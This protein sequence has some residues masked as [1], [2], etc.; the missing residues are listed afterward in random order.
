MKIKL[1]TV[2]EDLH[3]PFFVSKFFCSDCSFEYKEVYGK[4][5]VKLNSY[6]KEI[7]IYVHEII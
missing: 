7:V 3:L 2:K 6:K 5:P 4:I 1:N